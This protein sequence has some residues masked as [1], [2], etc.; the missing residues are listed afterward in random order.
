MIQMARCARLCSFSQSSTFVD[1]SKRIT[2][3]RRPRCS[4]I[5]RCLHSVHRSSARLTNSHRVI[6]GHGLHPSTNVALS[7]RSPTHRP[8]CARIPLHHRNPIL[9][10]RTTF[11][12][13]SSPLMVTFYLLDPLYLGTRGST[14]ALLTL[15][16]DLY[17]IVLRL[18]PQSLRLYPV[19]RDGGVINLRKKNRLLPSGTQVQSSVFTLG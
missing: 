19:H 14:R 6:Q 2:E 15:V 16:K 4:Q 7:H 8:R 12:S 13:Q 9:Q 3:I 11:I 18:L 10:A 5:A 1:G 17:L